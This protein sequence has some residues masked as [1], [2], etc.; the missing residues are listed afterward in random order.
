[1]IYDAL[2]TT[3]VITGVA[4]LVAVP[5][6]LGSLLVKHLRKPARRYPV[7]PGY[8]DLKAE[9]AAA[10]CGYFN[11]RDHMLNVHRLRE[12]GHG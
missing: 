10:E 7:T 2:A 1:M 12:T 6:Y 11:L 8:V 4:V 5:A 9:A 3:A